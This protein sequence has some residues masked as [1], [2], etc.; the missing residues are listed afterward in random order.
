MN[1]LMNDG[2]VC[3]TAPAT[4]GLLNILLVHFGSNKNCLCCQNMITKY[5]IQTSIII[6]P[7]TSS[8]R[9]DELLRTVTLTEINS[10]TLNHDQATSEAQDLSTK[11]FLPSL[12]ALSLSFVPT[13]RESP[14][15][16]K[17][18][19]CQSSSDI[20]ENIVRFVQEHNSFA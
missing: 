8:Y 19:C 20:S 15:N 3:R 7:F 16:L 10:P 11:N 6:N 14:G 1:E 13:K 17:S 4:P 18:L 12:I 9:I 2:G 5:L